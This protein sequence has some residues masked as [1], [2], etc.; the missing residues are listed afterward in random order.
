MICVANKYISEI[1]LHIMSIK[2]NFTIEIPITIEEATYL[3]KQSKD[4]IAQNAMDYK[5]I[6][7]IRFDDKSFPSLKIFNFLTHYAYLEAASTQLDQNQFKLELNK[8]IEQNIGSSCKCYTSDK[9]ENVH[10]FTKGI[11]DLMQA[12]STNPEKRKDIWINSISKCKTFLT[13]LC[14]FSSN[15]EE[16]E[17]L[18]FLADSKAV[19]LES[20]IK[21]INADDKNAPDYHQ[22]F[23]PITICLLIQEQMPYLLMTEI[24]KPNYA[25]ITEDSSLLA[26]QNENALQNKKI[27]ELQDEVN[28]LN[29]K[30]V[31][32]YDAIKIKTTENEMITLRKKLQ[33]ALVL[34]NEWNKKEKEFH[35]KIDEKE[36]EKTA[37]N[38]N[39]D[40]I[41]VK[42][43]EI[44]KNYQGLMQNANESQKLK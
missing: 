41:Q 8:I 44:E 4:Y 15:I 25:S 21:V 5:Y 22:E 43:S 13:A 20:Y 28:I 17:N 32:Q 24:I 34:E 23:K 26:S 6:R 38:Q 37:L 1:L 18:D 40:E 39:L 16:N 7:S 30:L 9:F 2:P 42:L 14:N 27:K 35:N 19:N 11:M 36:K 12:N 33:E 29:L 31:G 10:Y 3:S